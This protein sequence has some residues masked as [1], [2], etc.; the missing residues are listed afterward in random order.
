[1]GRDYEDEKYYQLTGRHKKKQKVPLPLVRG[2]R[3]AAAKRDAKAREEARQSGIVLPKQK[4][5]S[6]KKSMS[7][8]EFRKFGPAPNIGFM[9]SGVYRVS[10]T[11]NSNNKEQKKE[12]QEM[13]V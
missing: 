9:K 3:R 10:D 1:M 5:V 8:A 2:L 13:M 6:S 12:R 4:E 7:D 11:N